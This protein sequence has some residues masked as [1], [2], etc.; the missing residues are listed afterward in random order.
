MMDTTGR[1]EKGGNALSTSVLQADVIWNPSSD[2]ED[3][4]NGDDDE[5]IIKHDR[6]ST[7]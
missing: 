7:I 1:N 3:N 5:A 2:A 4:H 6:P